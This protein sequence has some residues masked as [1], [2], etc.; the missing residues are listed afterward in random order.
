MVDGNV[1]KGQ[2]IRGVQNVRQCSLSQNTPSIAYT[3]VDDTRKA[4]KDDCKTQTEDVIA[5]I[6]QRYFVPITH[7]RNLNYQLMSSKKTCLLW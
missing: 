2:I 4:L 6:L 5:F 1:A 3:A 7:P